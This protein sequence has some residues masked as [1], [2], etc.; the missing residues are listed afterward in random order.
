MKEKNSNFWFS[1]ETT[2]F[3]YKESKLRKLILANFSQNPR[4]GI[5]GLKCNLNDQVGEFRRNSSFL[6][7]VFLQKQNF[8]V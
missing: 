3:F 8:K 5:E 7:F 2:I 1:C 6:F 4:R